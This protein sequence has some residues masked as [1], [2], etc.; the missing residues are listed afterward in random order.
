MNCLIVDDE[1]L[2]RE[3]LEYY[4][5][6][7]PQLTLKAS[8]QNAL[9]AFSML[10]KEPVDLMFL[11]IRM[12]ELSGLDFVKT[13]KQPPRIIITTAYPEHAL[14]GYEL[15]VADYLLKPISFD[16]FLKAVDKVLKPQEP[17]ATTVTAPISTPEPFYI[18][19]DKKLVRL[20]ADE[21]VAIEGLRN[22]VVVHTINQQKHIVHG[23]LTHME[24]ELQAYPF[25][26]RVHKSFLINRNCIAAVT[27]NIITLSHN[28]EVPLG[29]SYR[30]DFLK[31]IRVL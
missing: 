1:A 13:L 17:S 26:V 6:K 8:C 10:S 2:A 22:Y 18:K 4:I 21:I 28:R 25:I 9:Q 27:G 7:V 3:V 20:Q 5:Q 16:R 11:D 23:T 14:E 24:S 31:Q 30:D 19:T 12:P 29:Q 15:N